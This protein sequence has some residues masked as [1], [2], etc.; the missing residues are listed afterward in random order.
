[1]V[2][3]WKKFLRCWC[4]TLKQL[5][6]FL[7]VKILHLA[8]HKFTFLP[9]RSNY[10]CLF[11]HFNDVTV[12]ITEWQKQHLVQPVVDIALCTA[13]AKLIPSISMLKKSAVGTS[14]NME[15]VCNILFSS[16]YNIHSIYTWKKF[17]FRFFVKNYQTTKLIFQ[18]KH[19]KVKYQLVFLTLD[20]SDW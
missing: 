4:D 17:F 12:A 16:I 13:Q 9:F 11:S 19:G 5:S 7:R 1:M 8:H 6:L 2:G 3:Q 18:F 14:L 10:S 15:V 20:Y